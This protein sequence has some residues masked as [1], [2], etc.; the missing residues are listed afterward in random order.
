MFIAHI[1]AGYICGKTLHQRFAKAGA[2]ARIL[3]LA[4]IIGGVAPDFDMFYFYLIDNRQTHHHMYWPHYPAVWL[5]FLVVSGSWFYFARQKSNAALACIFSVSGFIHIL[6]DTI[7]GDIFWL[8]P[9]GFQ[10][11]SLFTAPSLYKPWW[12]N[13][14]LHWSFLLELFVVF[15]A[16]LIFRRKSHSPN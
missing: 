8:A 12:L 9:F 14:L 5:A 15:W 1:P 16:I 7:V 10:P 13:F 4:A 11:F 2:P 6:L 3:I